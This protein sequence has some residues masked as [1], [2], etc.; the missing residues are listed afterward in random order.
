MENLGFAQTAKP[1]WATDQG[2]TLWQTL[3]K[4]QGQVFSPQA[5]HKA[6]VS[7]SGCKCEQNELLSHV[8]DFISFISFIYLLIYLDNC[9]Y[10]FIVVLF[11]NFLFN[12]FY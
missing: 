11:F 10:I 3:G 8:P 1:R 12:I 5:I 2:Q 9:V 7:V 4:P 6:W